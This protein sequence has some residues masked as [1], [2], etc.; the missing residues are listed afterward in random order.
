MEEKTD[1]ICPKCKSSLIVNMGRFSSYYTCTKFPEC[2]Y[3][4]ALE[5]KDSKINLPKHKND[6]AIDK[7]V[8]FYSSR[9]SFLKELFFGATKFPVVG[10]DISDYSIEVLQLNRDRSMARY[11]SSVMEKGIVEDGRI[12]NA[13][14][15]DEAFTETFSKIQP[16]PLLLKKEKRIKAIFSLPESKTF[17][18]TFSYNSSENL[19]EEIKKSIKENIPYLFGDLYWDY[20]LLTPL[21]KKKKRKEK[22]D[23]K[24][25]KVLVVAVPGDLVDQY[26]YFFWAHH[27]DPIAFDIEAAS[28]GKALL[29]KKSNQSI[30]VINIGARTTLINI[31]NPQ[32]ILSLS[33]IVP[34]AG[35][36]FTEKIAEEL[37][38]SEEEAEKI[39]K[40]IGLTK[41]PVSTI[42][43]K[44]FSFIFKEIQKAFDY[45]QK[46]FNHK[47]EK[48]ILIG[49]SAS[50][51]GVKEF[52]QKEF[53][54]TIEIG[55]PLEEIKYS[56]V[57]PKEKAVVFTNVIGLAL[58][59]TE[60][61]SI[62]SGIN[63]LPKTIQKKEK[64]EQTEKQRS[65]FLFFL[66]SFLV[67]VFLV[68]LV[69]I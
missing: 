45:Y 57:F 54:Q 62:G 19:E 21:A 28:V 63:L 1:K 41:P 11:G 64:I 32:G 26:L 61:N 29:L 37:K 59:G 23:E 52:F 22:E 43:E 67:V 12:L 51:S 69:T 56:E 20:L 39:K 53:K 40:K 46:K 50:L 18:R 34:Y 68:I 4:E 55:N 15:L 38:I 30:V 9:F 35:G 47:I 2:K 42:I 66:F 27:I 31:F 16:K 6:K 14:R 65:F 5:K 7:R 48:I 44:C 58:R 17:I 8:K 33:V 13:K 3:I 25:I 49:G 10:I 24:E 60:D 36:Y